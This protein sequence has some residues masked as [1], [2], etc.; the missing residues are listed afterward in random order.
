MNEI[1]INALLET[2]VLILAIKIP[3]WSDIFIDIQN[4]EA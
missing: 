3:S 4:N 2:E 1:D